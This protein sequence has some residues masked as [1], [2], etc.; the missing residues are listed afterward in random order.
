MTEK[1]TDNK[2]KKNRT[3]FTSETAKLANKKSRE[4]A[5]RNKSLR[6]WAKFYGKQA[7][8]IENAEGDEETTTW[9]GAVVVSMYK[10]AWGGDTK[11]AKLLTEI[12][13]QSVEQTVNVKAQVD[14][15][16]KAEKELTAQ[17]AAEFMRELETRM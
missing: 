6:D 11:A 13:G 12:T 17:E 3:S 4:S 5:R 8:K 7:I 2:K 1:K 14:A 15:H 9:D 10:A 16:V